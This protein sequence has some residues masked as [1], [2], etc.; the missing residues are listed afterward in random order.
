MERTTHSTKT[1][2]G[3]KAMVRENDDDTF[4]C[5][6]FTED[7]DTSYLT[8]ITLP[9]TFKYLWDAIGYINDYNVKE[10]RL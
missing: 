8:A 4:C 1:I 7:S 9:V 5:L 3:Y 2:D 10:A 6:Y